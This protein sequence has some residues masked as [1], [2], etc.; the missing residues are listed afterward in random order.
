VLGRDVTSARADVVETVSRI[1]TEESDIIDCH[2][3]V[4]SS[5][6]EE[7]R[8]VAH[9]RGRGDLPLSRMHQASD[10]IEKAVHSAHP[11]VGDVLIH[12]EPAG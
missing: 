9:V 6:G 1:A 3:V 8:V 12:F 4:V 2:E 10:R 5:S 11:D 7:L